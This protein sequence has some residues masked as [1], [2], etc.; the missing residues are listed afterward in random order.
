M[1]AGKIKIRRNSWIIFPKK[2]A[3]FNQDNLT[4]HLEV[5]QK[6][7]NKDDCCFFFLISEKELYM[8]RNPVVI[9][10]ETYC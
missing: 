10:C 7:N 3:S 6:G 5:K 2:T 4:V 9:F 1:L 8:Q